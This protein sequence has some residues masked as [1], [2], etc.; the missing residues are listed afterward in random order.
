MR[1]GGESSVMRK[2]KN[3]QVNKLE[4]NQR[5]KE[6]QKKTDKFK[7]KRRGEDSKNI[8]GVEQTGKKKKRNKG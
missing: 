6:M 5:R 3:K 2:N 8:K 1:M 4:T 7:S